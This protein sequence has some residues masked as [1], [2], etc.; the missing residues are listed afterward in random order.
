MDYFMKN[1]KNVREF[2]RHFSNKKM[3]FLQ[4]TTDEYHFYLTINNQKM[5]SIIFIPSFLDNKK[6]DYIE[7]MSS[8]DDFEP[9]RFLI[10]D[11]SDIVLKIKRDCGIELIYLD[12][13]LR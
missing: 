8:S 7:M 10:K 13:N 3:A 5:V 12:M 11:F 6:L 2:K 9:K 1:F 4:D